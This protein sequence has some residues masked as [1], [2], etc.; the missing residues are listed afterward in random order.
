MDERYI[1]KDIEEKW[2]KQWLESGAFKTE[3]NP[4]RPEYY[5][6]NIMC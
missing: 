5:V 6:Q 2:Q 1:A 3:E 4:Q